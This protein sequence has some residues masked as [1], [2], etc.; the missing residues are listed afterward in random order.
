MDSS[1]RHDP[2]PESVRPDEPELDLYTIP[3]YSSWFAWN[4]IHE[5]ERQ[6]LKEFF[7]GS[8]ISR[9]PKIYKEYRD[10]I[11]NKYRE[12]PTR[13]LTFTE[14][15]KSLIGDVTLLH[16]VFLFLETW[17]LINF[18]APPRPREGPDNDDRV[19][20][21]YGAPNGVRVVA[22]PNSLRPLSAPVVKGKSGDNGVAENGVKLPPLASYSDV[23]GD[24]KRLR[25]GNCGD[26]CNSEYYEHS[27][28]NFIVCVKCFKSRNFGENKSVDD[29]KLKD[30]GG[31][32][33][34]YGAV[35]TEEETLLLLDSVLKHGDDWDLV[36]QNVK[37]KS[38]LDCI[39]KLI[40]LP[41][42]ESLIDSA[43]GRGNSSGP[44][45]NINSAKPVLVPS[46]EHR[47]NIINEDQGYDGT[48]ENEQNGDSENQ[49]PPLKKKCTT[50]TSDADSSL[51]KQVALISTMVGPQITAA[52]AEA[53][54]AVLSDEMSC[55]REIFD[56][57][58][59]DVTNGLLS[60]T[61][62]YQPERAHNDEELEMKARSSPSESQETSQKKNDVPLPLR[63]RAAVATGLGA[64]AA[65]AKLL[66]E[67]EEREIEHLV[68]TIIET[69]LKKLQ[70]KIKHCEDAELLM[71]KEYAAIEE[72]KEYILGERINILQRTFSVGISKL[73]ELSS[74]QS[75]TGNLS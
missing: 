68:A 59:I 64:A 34:I 71:E 4:D 47:E 15:R 2:N 50:S 46:S 58:Q 11:I 67:Q 72:L 6:A 45:M 61:L 75:K 3:S 51:M 29:F 66:A 43:K 10:F 57:D 33:A 48:N 22:T 65:H 56:G 70:S 37:T 26:N 74:V 28:D 36:A 24:L 39:T 40:E 35:W 14:I 16:K 30:C 31:N 32:S 62:I 5:T 25:C 1:I 12:D 53:A 54:V 73:R 9:T 60:P 20:V 7:E 52:A 38:K 69:Q 42:G 17:G 23:F 44:S 27:K 63:I 19:R 41:F 55:P 13:R 49:E 8:S 21:E 18:V